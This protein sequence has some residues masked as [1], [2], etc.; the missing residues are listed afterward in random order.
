MNSRAENDRSRWEA[1]YAEKPICRQPP[2]EWLL[3]H[4][5]L[6]P[7]EGW[8]LDV[9]VGVGRNARALAA[10]GLKVT[11]LDISPTALRWA[12]QWSEEEGRPIEVIETDARDYR[13][14]LARFDVVLQFYFLAREIL[15]HLLASVRPGGWVILE[16]ASEENARLGG[17]GPK[18]PEWTLRHGELLEI[19]S[20]WEIIA[21]RRETLE[22]PIAVESIVARKPRT[23]SSE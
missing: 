10:H 22:G 11:G 19:F 7:H 3:R 2:H 16:T 18:N 9:A 5:P 14:P 13:W 6:L 20:G 17:L 21:H 8:A 1:K 23:S 15:P 12:A 4:L